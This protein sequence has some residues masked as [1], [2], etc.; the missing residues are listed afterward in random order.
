M[1]TEH[2]APNIVEINEPFNAAFACAGL[3]FFFTKNK[4]NPTYGN[5][6]PNNKNGVVFTSFLVGLL[7]NVL[8]FE[9][10]NASGFSGVPQY[11]QFDI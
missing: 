8:Q 3:S 9:Q 5:N 1:P 11:G 10:N 7:S 6:N 4:I 2:K